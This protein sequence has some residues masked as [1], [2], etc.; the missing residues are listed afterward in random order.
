[1]NV[2]LKCFYSILA[3]LPKAIPSVTCYT[4]V[5]VSRT[6]T[7]YF[8]ESL[9]YKIKECWYKSSLKLI[10]FSIKR[11]GNLCLRGTY[12]KIMKA[13]IEHSDYTT[14]KLYEIKC[15]TFIL[16][17]ERPVPHSWIAWRKVVS[18]PKHPDFH[19][20]PAHNNPTHTARVQMRHKDT[21]W[22]QATLWA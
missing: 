13:G 6:T 9:M 7:N 3:I 15:R 4:A 10:I 14:E 19:C 1:M 2:S 17:K 22:R 16:F 21:C 20:T 11:L 5:W 12:K 18:L 8:H